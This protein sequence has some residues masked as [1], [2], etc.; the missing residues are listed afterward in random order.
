KIHSKNIIV[1]REGLDDRFPGLPAIESSYRYDLA[2]HELVKDEDEDIATEIIR[3]SSGGYNLDEAQINLRFSNKI[4]DK[5]AK[6]YKEFKEAKRHQD[7]SERIQKGLQKEEEKLNDLYEKSDKAKEALGLKDLY[8]KLSAYLQSKITFNLVSKKYHNYPAVMNKL[9]GNEYT[10]IKGFQN[11]ID[12]TDKGI[13]NAKNKINEYDE[14]QSKLD[15]PKDGVS[16]DKINELNERIERISDHLRNIND[17]EHKIEELK[18]KE[19]EALK[20][21]DE[22]INPEKWDG[23]NLKN[24]SG[25]DQFLQ[26]AHKTR[27]E[28]QFLETEIN[29]LKKEITEKN[30]NAEVLNEGIRSLS[31]WLQEQTS[32][33]GISKWWTIALALVSVLTAILIF[34]I[35]WPG[36]IGI[37]FIIILVALPYWTKSGTDNNIRKND[38]NKT[39]LPQPKIWSIKGVNEKLN[40]IINELNEVKWQ[41]KIN[42]K[43]DNYTLEIEN[44]QPQ[45]NKINE[46]RDTWLKDIN[47]LPELPSTD[48][49]NYTE[50]YWFLDKVNKWQT[51]HTKYKVSIGEKNQ[52]SN[53]LSEDLEKLNQLFNSFNCQKAKDDIEAKSIFNK[54][55]KSENIRREALAEIK[56]LKTKIDEDNGKKDSFLKKI[57]EIYKILNISIGE[58]EEIRKLIERLEEYKETKEAYQVARRFMD[59]KESLLTAHSLYAKNKE[60]ITSISLDQ[61]EILMKEFEDDASKS[62]LINSKITEIQTNINNAKGSHLLEDAISRQDESLN[63]LEQLYEENLSS[64][65]GNL[66]I[67]QLKEKSRKQNQP[68][69]LIRANELFNNITSGRYHLLIEDKNTSALR[70][71]DNVLKLG[72]DLSELSTGTRIQLLLSVRIA[73]IEMQ[74]GIIKLPILAD[75]LL[76]NSDDI[77]AKAIIEAL[78]KISKEGRQVFYFTAQ[79]DE[80]SKWKSYLNNDKDISFKIFELTGGKNETLTHKNDK[81]EFSALNI[82]QDIPLAKN[83]SHEEYGEI[84]H[85]PTFNI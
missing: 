65:T 9:S 79:A 34:F 53:S 41:A 30:L 13:E 27:S 70:A 75:E 3:Q 83:K 77:R 38:Y 67:N 20:S 33:S 12:E 8:E 72:Q 55:K 26:S 45:L 81:V 25:L 6:E 56:R 60:K 15:L 74:E 19:I 76:A 21:I 18:T 69:V 63:N 46:T 5:G 22:S 16:D 54:L 23:L 7:E 36:L 35:G 52:F 66:I 68:K 50:L 31:F 62:E 14:K 44:L 47:A 85:V 64:L 10:D 43:I 78:I 1:Q 49:K 40:E 42:Q 48:L 80:V 37:A 84:L 39:S 58:K 24:L 71:Y 4:K 73:F 82:I 29:E 17:T 51:A 59:E 57:E 11:E 2:L 61:A 28:K 32:T